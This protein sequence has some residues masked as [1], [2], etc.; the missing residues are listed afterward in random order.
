[1]ASRGLEV[2]VDGPCA[3]GAA[4]GKGHPRLPHPCHERPQDEDGGPHGPH[5]IVGGLAAYDVS[6]VDA[7]GLALPLHLRPVV[8]Q[9]LFDRPDVGQIGD[10][11][12]GA[13]AVGKKGRHQ[14]RE[15]G[16]LR[17]ADSHPPFELFPTF[18]D[19]FVQMIYSC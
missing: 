4:P 15:S 6:A 18:N 12:V 19:E 14:D 8:G 5:E 3:D 10:V 13:P 9:E 7:Q 11:V 17:A 2:E 1:M 16:V